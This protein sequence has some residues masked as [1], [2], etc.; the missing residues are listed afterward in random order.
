[1]ANGPNRP[2]RP[3]RPPPG[4]RYRPPQAPRGDRQRGQPAARERAPGSR[5][6]QEA[7]PPKQPV[8]PPTGPV[9]VPS[10]VTVKD[11]SS[12]MGKTVPDIIKVMMG[13]GKMVTITQSLSDEEVELIAAELVPDRELQIKHAARGGARAGGVRG[14]GRGSARTGRRWSRSW[15]TSTT[16]RRPCSTQSARQRSSRPRPAE[17]RSTSA[18][19]R[20]SING[21]KITFLDTPGPRGLHGHARP[22]REVTDIAVLVVAADDGVMPQTQRVDLA[23]AR[24]RGAD[25]RRRQQDRPAGRRPEPG[26]R[27]PG[28]R[29]S[30]ARGLGREVQFADVSAKAK[31]EP[32]RAAREGAARRG[33][34]ARAEG[35]SE[36]RGVG[37]DH[38]VAARRGPR[39][40]RDHACPARHPPGRR[41]DRRRRRLGPGAR[42]LQLSRREGRRCRAGHPGRDPRLRSSTAGGRVL[43]SGRER[44]RGAASSRKSAASASGASSWRQQAG[45]A[46]SLERLF[47]QLQEGGSQDLN[48]VLKGDVVSS[49]EAAISELQK[50]QHPEVRVS[51]IHQGVG[52]DHGERRQPRR[53]LRTRWWSASTCG[54]RPRRAPARRARGRRDPH[55]PRHLPADRGHRAG[56][57]RHA[58]PG[59]DRGDD[60]RGRGARACSGSRDSARSP[61]ATVT[62]RRRPPRRDGA[63]RPRRHRHPRDDR[64]RS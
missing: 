18:P 57:R 32:R 3:I 43:A 6:R 9:S 8:A 20:S 40:C 10:G 1:M 33:C 47:E 49:V 38:R 25:R 48:L 27:R 36:G 61:A 58:P 42:P 45:G 59:H 15:A 34:R 22:R 37:S 26:P 14:R 51:V 2:N 64:S 23:R 55:L 7:R 30:P 5:E 12:A 46:V 31:R 44:A 62:E 53:G 35:E 56:A 11:L 24:G 28:G 39:S 29:R 21:R 41:L 4:R 60:R 50:I 63:R 17:S 13:L 52:G 54:L 16:A 19:T